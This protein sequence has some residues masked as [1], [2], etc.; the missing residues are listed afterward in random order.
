MFFVSKTRVYVLNE[1]LRILI[2]LDLDFMPSEGG[3]VRLIDI[4]AEKEIHK[5]LI[6][7]YAGS[8]KSAELLFI[9][10]MRRDAN[11]RSKLG[12]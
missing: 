11:E 8:Y 10:F 6:S 1:E 2:P 4:D 3:G 5:V 12:I 7:D 9:K